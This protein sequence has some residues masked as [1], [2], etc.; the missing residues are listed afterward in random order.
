LRLLCRFWSVV[1]TSGEMHAIA[2]GLGAD[3]PAC[4]RS[5]TMRGEGRGDRLVPVDND[6]RG[7][8]V[9][10]VNPRVGLST[11]GVF[12][13]WDGVDRGPLARTAAREAALQGRNDLQPPAS[14]LAPAIV[15]VLDVLHS[16]AGVIVARM[17]GSGATC[18]ALFEVADDRDRASQRI[19]DSHPDW[20]RLP[21]HIR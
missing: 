20:W 15:D 5:E 16:C 2:A 18:F 8:P 13:G 14:A 9:L 1:P 11:P 6:L 12:Q 3:V 10:L 7:T 17:S 19:R 4:L 21:S